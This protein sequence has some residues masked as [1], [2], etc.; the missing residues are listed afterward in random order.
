MVPD[1]EGGRLTP[2]GREAMPGRELE[3]VLGKD[4]PVR[5]LE[6]V[7]IVDRSPPYIDF[8]EG[9][10]RKTTQEMNQTAFPYA[11]VQWDPVTR[12]LWHWESPKAE[13]DRL[14][15]GR[16]GSGLRPVGPCRRGGAGSAAARANRT[17][18]AEGGAKGGTPNPRRTVRSRHAPGPSARD[19]HP[20]RPC[21]GRSGGGGLLASL[22]QLA[23]LPGCP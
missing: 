16:K 20:R 19:G 3:I 7:D 22:A 2:D 8:L 10:D 15:G 9:L 21:G 23:A 1:G 11:G 13:A 6:T 18:E 17:A 5:C 14:R 4:G 12:T